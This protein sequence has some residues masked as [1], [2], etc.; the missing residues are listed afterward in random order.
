MATNIF[1]ELCF[2]TH[3]ET[4]PAF[5]ARHWHF[6]H[7]TYSP[8]GVIAPTPAGYYSSCL[9]TLPVSLCKQI[10]DGF[11]VPDKEHIRLIIRC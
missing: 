6:E 5:P 1:C 7:P 4:P 8:A 3:W 11:E 9:S 2:T 10:G